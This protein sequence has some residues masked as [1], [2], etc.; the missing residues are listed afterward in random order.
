M[1]KN[2]IILY[3][4]IPLIILITGNCKEKTDNGIIDFM[5]DQ[6]RIGLWVNHGQ[7]YEQS[8]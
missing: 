8:D 1:I 4:S 3:L 5:N 6:Y 7:I 2:K